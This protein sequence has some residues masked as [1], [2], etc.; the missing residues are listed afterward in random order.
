[1]GYSILCALAIVMIIEGIGPMLF[2][3]RW[4]RYMS[5]LASQPVEQLRTIGGVLVT[6]GVVSLYFLL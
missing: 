4:Q 5:E 6:I 3:K 1:M 2:A